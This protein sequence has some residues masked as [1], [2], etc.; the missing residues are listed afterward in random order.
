MTKN[1]YKKRGPGS[2]RFS[3]YFKLEWHDPRIGAWRPLQKSFP[4][5]AAAILACA[6]GKQ[7]RI[8]E[9]TEQ[10]RRYLP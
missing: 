4:T 9:V 2:C 10:G 6:K 1:I 3:D 5:H 7:W 8:M